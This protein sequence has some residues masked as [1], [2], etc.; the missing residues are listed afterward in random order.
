MLGA[1]SSPSISSS[2]RLISASRSTT[3]PAIDDAFPVD[4]VEV[5][6]CSSVPRGPPQDFETTGENADG[7]E[8]LNSHVL[9]ATSTKGALHTEAV[10]CS[11]LSKASWRRRFSSISLLRWASISSFLDFS[12]C[13]CTFK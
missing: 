2:S 5:V 7:E 10:V 3:L 4:D 6:L 11:A 13:K 8:E 1:G 12:S 9:G